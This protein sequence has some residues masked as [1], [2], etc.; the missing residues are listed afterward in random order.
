MRTKRQ[1]RDLRDKGLPTFVPKVKYT[2]SI[3]QHGQ[4]KTMTQYEKSVFSGLVTT[5]NIQ[6]LV[7]AISF[8]KNSVFGER[9]AAMHILNFVPEDQLY[10]IRRVCLPFHQRNHLLLTRNPPFLTR[11]KNKTAKQFWKL[12]MTDKNLIKRPG[13]QQKCPTTDFFFFFTHLCPSR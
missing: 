9:D 7:F 1:L 13:R 10:T 12:T 8:T 4:N 11:E 2:Y 3:D 6:H 5:D